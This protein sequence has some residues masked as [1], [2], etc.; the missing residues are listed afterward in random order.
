MEAEQRG[1]RASAFERRE[2]EEYPEGMA[3]GESHRK[4]PAGHPDATRSPEA[5][6]MSHDAGWRELCVSTDL[7][8][9]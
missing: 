7:D 9:R 2:T 8:R 6:K 5:S 1:E 4:G 3:T